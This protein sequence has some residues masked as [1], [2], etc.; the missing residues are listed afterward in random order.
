MNI[1]VSDLASTKPSGSYM[2]N[3]LYQLWGGLLQTIEG[4]VKL[5]DDD[6]VQRV[7]KASMLTVVDGLGESN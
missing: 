5:A 2:A 7:N 6:R 3:L 4:L 1:D